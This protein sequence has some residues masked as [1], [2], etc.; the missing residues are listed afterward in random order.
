MKKKLFALTI[1]AAMLV[2]APTAYASDLSSIA[3]G[4]IK[5]D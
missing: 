1:A 3:G 5:V 4:G 2:A